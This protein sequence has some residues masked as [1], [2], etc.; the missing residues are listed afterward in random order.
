MQVIHSCHW[1]VVQ[2]YDYIAF[3]QARGSRRAFVFDANDHYPGFFRKSI[4]AHHPPMNRNRL[5]R[6]AD[7][8][9]SDPSIAQQP[10]G[11]EFRGIDA[12]RKTDSLRRQNRRRVDS[13]DLSSRVDQWATGISR[14]Q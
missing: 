5:R 10:A 6:D 8:A 14:I 13:D 4:E 7:V 9:A 1:R 2:S 12:D 11:D 3:A